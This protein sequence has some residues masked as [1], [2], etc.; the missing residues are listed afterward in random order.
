M[1]TAADYRSIYTATATCGGKTWT[2]EVAAISIAGA[3][4]AAR[5]AVGFE[6]PFGI[7]DIS[8][9]QIRVRKGARR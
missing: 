5:V 7:C 6:K 8:A 9:V 1:N 4:Y 3:A 2:T